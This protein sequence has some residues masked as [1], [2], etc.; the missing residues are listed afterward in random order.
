MRCKR[1]QCT[2]QC[3][4]VYNNNGTDGF[5]QNTYLISAVTLSYCLLVSD[6][7]MRKKIFKTPT[8]G[9]LKI[10]CGYCFFISF[11]AIPHN[12]HF[13]RKQRCPKT[14]FVF[15]R[16][17]NVNYSI[18]GAVLSLREIAAACYFKF[19][20]CKIFCIGI[21]QCFVICFNDCIFK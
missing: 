20:I 13:Y 7:A 21:E 15:G 12:S 9:I 14:A 6:T 19:T 10:F 11:K 17:K 1:Q 2:N 16:I 8:V 3:Q 5:F 18:Y 4:Y